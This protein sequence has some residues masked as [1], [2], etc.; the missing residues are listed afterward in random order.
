MVLCKGLVN[1]FHMTAGLGEQLR[2]SE[3]FV[4]GAPTDEVDD[5]FIDALNEETIAE[6][7][8]HVDGGARDLFCAC[9]AQEQYQAELLSLSAAPKFTIGEQ[10]QD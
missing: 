2:Q 1:T 3:S 10:V 6:C 4:K 9:V 5:K 7:V 8:A